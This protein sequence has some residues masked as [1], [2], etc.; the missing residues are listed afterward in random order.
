MTMIKAITE[1]LGTGAVLL[2]YAGY[3]LGPIFGLYASVTNGSFLN[4]VLSLIIPWY[5]M[6]YWML[7]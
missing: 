5:G 2:L 7:S 6:I 4:A 1:A 3:V